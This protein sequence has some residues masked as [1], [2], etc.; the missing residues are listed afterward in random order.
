MTKTKIH[1]EGDMCLFLL[2]TLWSA[3]VL[4]LMSMDSPLHHIYMRVDSAWYFMEGKAMMNG[5]R[6]YVDFADSKG[7]LLWLF[8]GIAYLISPRNYFGLYVLGCLFYGGI[9]YYNH[10]MAR[11]LLGDGRR[12]LLVVVMMS[13]FYFLYWFHN[14]TRV[15]DFATLFVSASLYYLFLLLYGEEGQDKK[16]CTVRRYGLVMGGCFMALM[17]MKFNIA[18]MQGLMVFFAF[19]YY[20]RENRRLVF[21]F[22]GWT[23]VG[24]MAVA[25]PFLVYL[26]VMGS[27]SGFIQEY[28]INTT[29]TIYTHYSNTYKDEL[30]YAWGAPAQ[31]F[32]LLAIIAGGWLLSRLLPRYRYFPLLVGLFFYVIAVRHGYYYYYQICYIFIIYFL[33]YIA[34]LVKNPIKIYHLGIAALIVVSWGIFDNCR[35]GS[36]LKAVAKWSDGKDREEYEEALNITKAMSGYQKP[37]I[38]NL[39][40]YE[41]GFEVPYEGLPAGKYYAFQNGMTPEMTAEHVELLK[42]GMADFVIVGDKKLCDQWGYTEKV[43]ESYGY[44]H[45][46]TSNYNSEAKY[47]MVVAVYKNKRLMK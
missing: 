13:W 10:K 47:G 20:V 5:L 33:I 24:M 9:L 2:L 6:P 22:I 7:P 3:V 29:L 35:E 8:Y 12:P 28:F 27:F 18:A 37:T 15:E 44:K 32:Q 42:S 14:E 40:Y 41:Q 38:L 4:M 26:L 43:I 39:L 23:A 16:S 11:L 36:Q 31:Q 46:L 1:L 30:L 17:L 34:S 19:W 25:L 45:I 21:S